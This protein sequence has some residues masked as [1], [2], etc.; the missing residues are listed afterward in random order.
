MNQGYSTTRKPNQQEPLFLPSFCDI[1]MVFAVVVIAELLAF[2]LVLANSH[3]DPW[4][5]LGLTSLF[6]QWIALSSAAVLCLARPMLARI[7]NTAAALISYLLLLLTTVVITELA[8]QLAG[9]QAQLGGVGHAGF[10][11][12]NLGISAILSALVLRYLYVQHQWRQKIQAE[13]QA[14][15]Q[16]LQAR[17]RPHFLFNSMNSIASLTRSDPVRAE[18]AVQDLSDLFRISLHDA[19][20][21]VTLEDELE[22]AQ[23]YLRMEALRLGDRLQVEWD[24]ERLP[25][26][27]LVPSLILQPLLENAVYHGVEP[28]PQG[29]RISISGTAEGRRV[30]ITVCNPRVPDTAG[31]PLRGNGNQIA[32]ENIRLRLQLA[33]GDQAGVALRE[34]GD[35]FETTLYFPRE[36]M[37]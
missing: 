21:R 17:I 33:F 24:I 15:V 2:V 3:N 4:S 31:K 13:A 11:F 6:V 12:R 14:R 7:S 16:A 32:L 36:K 18:Q 29:G 5:E 25:R 20:E 35:L 1:R 9:L 37:Q 30:S 22:V 26:K 27:R 19:S 28:L 34:T 23:G 10:L 8:Y